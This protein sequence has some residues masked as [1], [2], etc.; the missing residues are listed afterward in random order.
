MADNKKYYYLK[1]KENFFDTDEM[2]VLESMP[3]G[4]LYSN[5]LLKLYLRS[6]KY[7]GR[8]MFNERIPFNSTMLA[9]VTRHS[10][11]VIEKAMQIFQDLG[12]VEVL[13]NGAIYIS[14]I[15]NFIGKST[16]EADRIR[17]YRKKI[18]SEKS[19]VQ[20][21]Y[22]CTPEIEI[23]LKKEIEPKKELKKKSKKKATEV[24][25]LPTLKELEKT[26]SSPLAQAVLDWFTYKQQRGEHYTP[27]GLK[28]LL[29]QIKNNANQYSEQAVIEL[30]YNCMSSNWKGIIWDKL[31]NAQGNYNTPYQKPQDTYNPNAYKNT[32]GFDSL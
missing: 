26:F 4:Y 13:D 17:E 14:D 3:D 2:I 1:L 22:K 15:Q 12:L 19:G 31:K 20:M 28:S 32:G 24:A 7:D 8:L 21:L 10:V 6:L 23:E 29:T 9:Q 5:I 25:T 30:I 11:G 27:I 16:N 18:E